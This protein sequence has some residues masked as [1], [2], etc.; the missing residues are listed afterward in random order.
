MCDGNDLILRRIDR[1]KKNRVMPDNLKYGI[2][3]FMNVMI[4]NKKKGKDLDKSYN[5]DYYKIKN[6]YQNEFNK[7]KFTQRVLIPQKNTE[8]VEMEKTK[9]IRKFGSQEK[10]LRHTT[11]GTFKSLMLKTPD[12]FPTKGRKRINKSIDCGNK[13][14]S[15]IFL[16]NKMEDYI[17]NDDNRLFGVE[18]K[19]RNRF[20][21]EESVIPPY[22][23]A[24]R[25]FFEFEELSSLY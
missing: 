22:K 12:S 3:N 23:L 11:D 18:R 9:R 17:K 14:D 16:V 21:N 8:P 6:K 15:D 7:Y 2:G 19:F 1:K 20:A 13:P 5:A 4:I 10:N 25:H 24:K